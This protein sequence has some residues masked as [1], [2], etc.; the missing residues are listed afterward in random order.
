MIASIDNELALHTKYVQTG[1]LELVSGEPAI[2][3]SLGAFLRK[4]SVP[5]SNPRESHLYDKDDQ[6]H[7]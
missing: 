5:L 7:Q 4:H 6:R 3:I 1:E 2:L